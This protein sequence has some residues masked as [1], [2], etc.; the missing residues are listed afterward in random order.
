M[1]SIN[2][3]NHLLNKNKHILIITFYAFVM[4]SSVKDDDYLTIIALT[5]LAIYTICK[6][7]NT[8]FEGQTNIPDSSPASSSD[9]KSKKI[10]HSSGIIRQL[11][12]SMGPYDGLCLQTGNSESWMKSPDEINLLPNNSLFSYLSS[13][14]PQKP[15]FSDNSALTGPPIDGKEG[16]PKKMFMFANNRTSPNCCPSSYTTST[17]CV[18]TTKNQRNYIA[19]RGNQESTQ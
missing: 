9:K 8:T 10:S 6:L 11:P 13:Q 17:G 16:S 3:I 4:I 12:S 14:G 1:L 2:E 19:S 15:I 5:S 7:K 18:C